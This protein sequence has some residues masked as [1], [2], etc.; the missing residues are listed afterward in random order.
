VPRSDGESENVAAS[1]KAFYDSYAWQ[2]DETTGTLQGSTLDDDLSDG[3]QKYGADNESRYRRFFE[4]GGRFFLDVGCGA[5]PRRKLSASFK[6]H[7]CVDVSVVGLREARDR[8]GDSGS[9]ILADM[10]ALPFRGDSLDAALAGHS[11]YHV[12]KDLQTPVLKELYR[13]VKPDKTIL[14]FYSS[15]HNLISLAH[16]IPKALLGFG[17]LLLRPLKLRVSPGSSLRRFRVRKMSAEPAF[18]PLYAYPHNPRW[19]AR[20]FKNADV[21]CLCTL[22][23]YDTALLSKLHLFRVVVPVVAFFERRFPHAMVYV[24]KYTCIRIQKTD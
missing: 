16:M 3:A 2:R 21:T 5:Q 20:T 9:Y 7:L 8:I 19:L 10:A 4:Y 17:N 24:G 12:D 11:L 15:R 14:V 1:V 22:T 6:E 23:M 18:P 13:V